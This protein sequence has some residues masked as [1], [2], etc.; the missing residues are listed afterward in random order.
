MEFA[1][2]ASRETAVTGS[3][4][5]TPAC[6]AARPQEHFMPKYVRFNRCAR[7]F[8][9]RVGFANTLFFGV[10]ATLLRG[11]ADLR[12]A[13]SVKGSERNGEKRK[14]IYVESIQRR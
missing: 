10:G 6:A 13:L 12:M 2:P 4:L 3:G 9:R 5:M 14:V 8:T 11:H 1:F 7:S